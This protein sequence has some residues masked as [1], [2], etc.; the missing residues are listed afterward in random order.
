[1]LKP[2]RKKKGSKEEE[3]SNGELMPLQLGKAFILCE[4]WLM[5]DGPELLLQVDPFICPNL[6]LGEPA[7][8]SS[9]DPD[10]MAG[11]NWELNHPRVLAELFDAVP[12]RYHNMMRSPG[13]F[14]NNV[15]AYIILLLLRY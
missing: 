7:C 10:L 1:M 15:Q 3:S 2:A 12:K 11:I 13:L 6:N 9:F 8:F 5:L 4:A 14:K